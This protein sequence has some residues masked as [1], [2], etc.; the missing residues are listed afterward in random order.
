MKRCSWTKIFVLIAWGAACGPDPEAPLFSAECR[1]DDDAAGIL[2]HGIYTVAV[3]DTLRAGQP[4]GTESNLGNTTDMQGISC[5]NRDCGYHTHL[6]VF[7][8]RLGENINPLDL[9]QP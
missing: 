2:M 9:L 6:N 7:D 1:D 3:G 8:K 5:R 4:I